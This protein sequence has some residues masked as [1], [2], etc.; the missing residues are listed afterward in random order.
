MT[1]DRFTAADFLLPTAEVARRLIGVHLWR[2]T[3]QGW[4]RARILE[5]EA[6]GQDDPACHAFKG[7][8][9]RNAPMFGPPGTSYVYFI[10]GSCHCLNVVTGPEGVGEAVLIRAV[11]ALQG[12]DWMGVNRPVADARQ[13]ANGPGKLCQALALD[14]SH[15]GLDLIAGEVLRLVPG[16]TPP[17]VAVGPRVGISQAVDWPLRFAWAG[18][19]GVSRPCP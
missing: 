5:T 6:Y 18:H 4:A 11:E 17:A 15:N 7:P 14:R 16:D 19:R 8:T 2:A 13:L 12:L 1:H 9:G 10:Y 3:P